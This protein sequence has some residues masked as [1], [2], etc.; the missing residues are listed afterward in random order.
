MSNSTS[1]VGLFLQASRNGGRSGEFLV[2]PEWDEVAWNELFSYMHPVQIKEGDV[3]IQKGKAERSLYFVT[4]GALEA[5]SS[6]SDSSFGPIV[7]ILPGSLV[8]EVAFF[9]G[10]PRSTK[11]WAITDSDLMRLDYVDYQR[12]LETH[13]LQTV[14]LLLSL[15]RLIALRLRRLSGQTSRQS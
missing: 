7:K 6:I 5:S 11:V 14:A 9:D 1:P 10:N 4:S 3:L 12:Y 8:G 2:I 15:G 13:P